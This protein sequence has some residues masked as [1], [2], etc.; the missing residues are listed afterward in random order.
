MTVTTADNRYSNFVIFLLLSFPVLIN[1]VKIFGNLILLILFLVGFYIAITQRKNP[2]LIPELKL[3]SWITISY[4]AV[5]L[6]TLIYADGWSAQFHHLGRK[7]HFLLAPL[8]ALA[9]YKSNISIVKLLFS[10]KLGLL[11][12]GIITIIQF[13]LDYAR[14]SGMINANVF[15]DLAVSMLFLSMVRIFQESHKER[16]LTLIAVIFGLIAIILSASRGS[17]LSFLILLPFFLYLSYFKF[18]KRLK[19]KNFLIIFTA[20]IV[21]FGTILAKTSVI[22]Q[23]SQGVEEVQKWKDGDSSATSNGM[24]MEMWKSGLL[25][26]TKAPWFGHGYRNANKVA[27]EYA[28]L[29]HDRISAFTHLHNEYITNLVSSGILGLIALFVL[30]LAPLVV[31]S[32]N[33]KF[34]DRYYFAL[35]GVILCIGYITFGFTHIAFGEEHMNA[36]YVFFLS[37]LLPK[38]GRAVSV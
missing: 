3:F 13:F 20:L 8:I 27:T 23:F 29:Y 28:T 14:P 9:I 6:V 2:F 1:S 33:L 7:L 31:F 12:I 38:M 5:I 34:D 35:M 22:I 15:G 24:R 4:F 10:L 18:S 11:L 16:T 37:L 21:V 17:W 30:L 19:A 26:S 25:A 36:F 32:K